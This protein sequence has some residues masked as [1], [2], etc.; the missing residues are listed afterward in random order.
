MLTYS[1]KGRSQQGLGAPRNTFLHWT[2]STE[3]VG[4]PSCPEVAPK[5]V[6]MSLTKRFW[7]KVLDAKVLAEQL[8]TDFVT[9]VVQCTIIP[10]AI[11][12]NISD[13]IILLLCIFAFL[14]NLIIIS[15]HL[16]GSISSRPFLSI[17][18]LRSISISSP[19]ISSNT[20]KNCKTSFQFVS[21]VCQCAT[22]ICAADPTNVPPSVF[23][24]S[25]LVIF[26][27]I[28]I[29]TVIDILGIA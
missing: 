24:F 3:T 22:I 25:G 15:S 9:G 13:P 23:L 20:L 18:S 29:E 5:H 7:I 8:S 17:S 28:I 4:T 16:F 6:E 12:T 19:N 2:K 27:A 26:V 11:Y 10:Y 14:L 21:K 1:G